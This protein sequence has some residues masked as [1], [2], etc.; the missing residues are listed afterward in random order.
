MGWRFPYPDRRIGDLAVSI[1]WA[2]F[3]ALLDGLKCDVD[4]GQR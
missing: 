2:D 4:R 3:T 1:G